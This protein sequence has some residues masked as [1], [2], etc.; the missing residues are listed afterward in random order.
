M[1]TRTKPPRFSP[2]RYRH[3]YL[4]A[5]LLL[6]IAVRPFLAERVLGVALIEAF[7]FATLVA[8][9]YAAATGRR[10]F[11]TLGVLAVL[12]VIV[13]MAWLTLRHD[14]LLYGFLG[15]YIV[16]YCVVTVLLVQSLFRAQDHITA[17][18][19]YGA[20][21]VYLILGLIWSMAYTVLELTT[22]G[23]FR[24]DT[25]GLLGQSRF[26]RFL[27]FSFTTLTT[28]GYGNVAPTTPRA[29]AMAT[30]EAITG[31]VYLAVVIA[32]FVALQIAQGQRGDAR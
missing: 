13:R 1:T 24:F 10:K 29:D 19:L 28:L 5:S 18:T 11:I 17:D 9:A 6:V 25:E 15:C 12:S 16:F 20:L 21:S 8:G 32:R 26:D 22:P 27:G 3:A 30:L 4:L 31:Q 23:S 7:L 2:G 14:L